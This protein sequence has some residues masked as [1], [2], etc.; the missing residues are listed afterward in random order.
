MVAT[1]NE[2][3]NLVPLLERIWRAVDVDVL[4]IDDNSPDG[5]G[6]IADSVAARDARVSVVHRAT[7]DGV[8][9]AHKLAFARAL[10]RGYAHVVEMDADF[11]H[12]PEDLANLIAAAASTG[13]ALGSRCVPGARIVGRAGWRNLLTRLGGWYARM[14]LGLSVRDCTGGYRCSSA[15]ALRGLDLD[16][17]ESHGYGFQ[18]ELNWAWKRAGVSVV[19]IPI[20]FRDRTVGASKMTMGILIESLVMVLRLRSGRV[21]CAARVPRTVIAAERST[22]TEVEP[23]R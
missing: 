1:Y 10:E 14:A 16:R 7:K 20:T 15:A 9:S 11:S 5:T 17:V 23:A 19:E 6:A 2:R 3:D 4:V 13:V 8:A 12:P 18:L 21:A 22:A